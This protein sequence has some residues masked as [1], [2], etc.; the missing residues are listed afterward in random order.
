[1]DPAKVL[2]MARELGS[3]I[4]RVLIVGCEPRPFS[5]D[6]EMQMGLSEPVQAAVEEA[7][8]VIESLVTARLAT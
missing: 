7:I 3:T 5:P 6:D 2:R 1:M 4:P 8:T